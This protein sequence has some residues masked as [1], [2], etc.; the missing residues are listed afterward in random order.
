M[1]RR[2][3]ITGVGLATPLGNTAGTFSDELFSGRS[4]VEQCEYDGESFAVGRVVD[5]LDIKD[6]RRF[7]HAD[8][9]TLF[10][11][12][13]SR[14]AFEDASIAQHGDDRHGFGVFLG[15]GFAGAEMLEASYKRLFEQGIRK[16]RPSTVLNC[17]ANAPSAQLSIEHG[18]K[19]PSMNISSACSSSSVAIFQGVEHVRKGA[20]N[21]AVVGGTEA[22]LTY[23]HLKAWQASGAL[24]LSMQEEGFFCSPFSK[25]RNGMVLGE[26]AVVFILEDLERVKEQGRSFYGEIAG[27]AI[28]SNATHMVQSDFDGQ[29]HVMQQ[30]IGNA[31]ISAQQLDYINAHA[32][33]TAT[34]DPVEAKAIKELLSST[35]K[36]CMVSSTKGAYGHLLGASGAVGVLASILSMK[37]GLLPPNTGTQHIDPEMDISI[38]SGSGETRAEV[39]YALANSFAFGGHN[40]SLVLRNSRAIA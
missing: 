25:H 11:L 15:A 27:G 4:R 8:R 19:G 39:E 21:V 2:V 36:T 37:T 22:L 31:G 38:V 17:M 7:A 35:S 14:Q 10:A 29:V 40:C 16:T 32:T 1:N 30:A 34:G 28:T 9:S 6:I 12:H 5:P 13:A 26:G 24:S 23:G 3:A 20:D 18:I 33:G